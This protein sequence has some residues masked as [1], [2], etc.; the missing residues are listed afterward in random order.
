MLELRTDSPFFFAVQHGRRR[1]PRASHSVEQTSSAVFPAMRHWRVHCAPSYCAMPYERRAARR[2]TAKS[3]F[4]RTSW[5]TTLP[6]QSATR[7]FAISP[8]SSPT[9]PCARGFASTLVLS[10][11]R[12]SANEAKLQPEKRPSL[13][14]RSHRSKARQK[15]ARRRQTKLKRTHQQRLPKKALFRK[16]LRRSKLQLSLQDEHPQRHAALLPR[17]TVCQHVQAAPMRPKALQAQRT[18]PP[19]Q[20]MSRTASHGTLRQLSKL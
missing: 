12:A 10:S 7:A 5:T 1:V 13:R 15:R 3:A 8:R 18:R 16:T 20:L 17:G 4:R 14:Q 9:M 19:W 11:R 6:V 2:S